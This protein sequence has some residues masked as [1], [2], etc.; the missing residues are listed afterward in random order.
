[1]AARRSTAEVIFAAIEIINPQCKPLLKIVNGRGSHQT[2]PQQWATVH[3]LMGLKVML[4]RLEETRKQYLQFEGVPCSLKDVFVK[5]QV[6]SGMATA[7]PSAIS[8]LG[9]LTG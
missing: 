8:P 4:H 3:H 7:C 6:K 1:M 2:T 9:S 5:T